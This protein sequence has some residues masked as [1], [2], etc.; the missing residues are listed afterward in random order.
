MTEIDEV[1]ARIYAKYKLAWPLNRA[2]AAA[3]ADLEAGDQGQNIIAAIA[4]CLFNY[5]AKRDDQQES[6]QAFYRQQLFTRA[7]KALGLNEDENSWF[8]IVGQIEKL[9]NPGPTASFTAQLFDLLASALKGGSVV[10]Y[11]ADGEIFG[12][13]E[14]SWAVGDWVRLSVPSDLDYEFDFEDQPVT[15]QADGSC[16]AV[17]TNRISVMLLITMNRPVRASDL[18]KPDGTGN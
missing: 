2:Q 11:Q 8:D 14:S 5:N 6:D 17:R 12:R 18:E 15:V 16:I 10:V 9:A 7:C 1:A 4:E 13:V 3:L